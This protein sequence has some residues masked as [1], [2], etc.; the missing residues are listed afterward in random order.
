V[1]AQVPFVD[2]ITTMLDDDTIPPQGMMNGK[3]N[4]KIL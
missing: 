1:I 2:V 4:E 3:S